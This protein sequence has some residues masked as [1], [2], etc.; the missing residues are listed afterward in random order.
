M[1]QPSSLTLPRQPAN[2]GALPRLAWRNLWRHRR[3]TWL[4]MLVVI[5]AT[6][7]IILFWGLQDG[8][9]DSMMTGN[10]RFLSAPAI[11]SSEAYFHDPDP[12]NGL[13]SLAFVDALKGQPGVRNVAPRLEFPGLLR[14]AYTSQ[15]VQARG[16]DPG[17]EAGV[18][19]IPGSI[20]QGRMLQKP[21]EV[22]LGK[23]LAARLDVR[24]GERVVLEVSA[25][26][27]Q[28]AAGLTLV[29]VAD[30][31]VAAVDDGA[32]LLDIGQARGLTGLKTAT[33]VALDVPRGQEAAVARAVQ[34]VLPGGTRAYDLSQLLG[35]LSQAVGTKQASI[36]VIALLFSIFAALAVTSTVLVSVLERTREFGVTTAVG[37]N[38]RRM[39]QMV[40]LEAV[41]AT[42]L[43]WLIGL[44]V[45]YGVNAWLAN[46]NVLGP[47]FAGYGGAFQ[48]LGTGQE[49]YTAQKPVYAL[50]AA[51]TIALA[52]IF[53]VW[54]PARRVLRLNAAE[55]LKTD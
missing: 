23:N 42:S 30:S 33:G 45:G 14:S 8:F 46:F 52:A 18:S 41:F 54:I 20:R 28:Q 27:G 48:S 6:V 35:G 12:A 31:G 39:A 51:G 26:A 37:M 2:F 49:I 25:S 55:A 19:G 17:L 13:S 21:G 40:T 24:L 11:V 10:A 29:G 36:T 38:P 44:A 1:A 32:V 3:R 9:F 16:V 7:S 50:Y 47:L 53:S 15:G 5:Y 43:G 4:L 22:V 34:P